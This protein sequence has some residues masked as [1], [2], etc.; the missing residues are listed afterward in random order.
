MSDRIELRGL[1]VLAICGALPEEKDR[2]QPLEID[3]V[4]ELDLSRPG[5]TDALA[6]TVDYGALARAVATVAEEGRYTLLE[7]L[8]QCIADDVGA[9]S[10]VESVTVS[11][12]KIRPP[13]PVHLASA[14]VCIRRTSTERRSVAQDVVD[15]VA[16]EG[17]GPRRRAFLG[18]G[19]NIGDREARLR[20]ALD[21][22]PDV[23]AVSR[24]Y[25]TEPLGGPPDQGLYLNLVVELDTDVSPRGLLR[26]GKCLERSAGRQPAERDA[27]R[28]LDVDV[29]LVGDLVVN[30]QDLVVPHPR[31]LERRFVLR[32]LADLAPELVPEGWERQAT[33]VIQ[34][35]GTL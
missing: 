25:S 31:M 8:A 13:T 11:V 2:P 19:S 35:L 10:R 16:A 20:E 26:I 9:D 1:R 4:V 21:A 17:G 28:P 5:R 3:L 6:D 12:H 22:L 30:E 33:G 15:I 18:L 24:V 7:H 32:P 27:P 29:L 34:G 23:K 14:G